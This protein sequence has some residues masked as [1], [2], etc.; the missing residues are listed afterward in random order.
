MKYDSATVIAHLVLLMR[1]TKG[2]RRGLVEAARAEFPDITDYA[3]NKAL[4]DAR[5]LLA[6]RK[7]IREQAE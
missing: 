5:V 2:T 7:A 6:V 3:I 1:Q 4:K